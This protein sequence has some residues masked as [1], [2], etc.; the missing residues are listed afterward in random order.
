[1][2]EDVGPAWTLPRVVE[3]HSMRWGESEMGRQSRVAFVAGAALGVLAVGAATRRGRGSGHA[4]PVQPDPIAEPSSS[5]LTPDELT[6]IHAEIEDRV[7]ATQEA[8]GEAQGELT[9][10]SRNR[11]IGMLM[12]AV[13]S[14]ALVGLV[15]LTCNAWLSPTQGGDPVLVPREWISQL[16]RSLS[17]RLSAAMA[18]TI[19]AILT[20][21]CM[22]ACAASVIGRE[23]PA[24]VRNQVAAT[25][26]RDNIRWAA[27]LMATGAVL[28]SVFAWVGGP[29]RENTIAL[30]TVSVLAA[31]CL[32]LA[33]SAATEFHP[34][35]TAIAIHRARANLMNLSDRGTALPSQWQ[36]GPHKARSTLWFYWAATPRSVLLGLCVAALFVAAFDLGVWLAGTPFE[37]RLTVLAM[38]AGQ[39]APVTVSFSFA[40]MIVSPVFVGQRAA[41]SSISR[42]TSFGPPLTLV[43]VLTA[44]SAY[45]A[46]AVSNPFVFLAFLVLLGGPPASVCAIVVLERRYTGSRVL[47]WLCAPIWATKRSLL[48]KQRKAIYAELRER[49]SAA[50]QPVLTTEEMT[51][52]IDSILPAKPSS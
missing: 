31:V 23:T 39:V 33:L 1:M 35:D 4:N 2:N 25:T 29:V 46:V 16:S 37:K 42:S 8:A 24:T 44:L 48:D 6:R 51:S 13:S 19:A 22:S 30:A 17:G 34:V 12:L 36:Q 50:H 20:G 9:R 38:F 40:A 52:L 47:R 27:S 3:Y 43:I 5:R 49:R 28:V 11:L 26:W 32:L 41:N 21:L 14:L 7:K 18:L 10:E 15:V 45:G